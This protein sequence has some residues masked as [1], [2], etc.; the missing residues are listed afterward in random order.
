MSKKTYTNEFVVKLNW[1]GVFEMITLF[2]GIL[3]SF[4]LFGFLW[5]QINNTTEKGMKAAIVLSIPVLMLLFCVWL[6]I[7]MLFNKIEVKGDNIIIHKAFGKITT[8]NASE[9]VSY[10]NKESFQ[11]GHRYYHSLIVY[12]EKDSIEIRND[13]YK[14]Y[15]LLMYYLSKKCIG[16]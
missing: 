10:S 11:K 15:D 12:G 16:K 9:I 3:L 13:I 1:V 7:P 6:I 14:N 2:V 5:Q 8:V 4:V